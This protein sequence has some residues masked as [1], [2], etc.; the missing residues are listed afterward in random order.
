GGGLEALVLR[1]QC[2]GEDA[3]VAPSSDAELRGVGEAGGDYVID[4]GLQVDDFEVAPVRGDRG[5]ILLAAAGAAA[6]VHVHDDVAVG[7]EELPLEVERVGV[8][9]V[10]SAVDTEERRVFAAVLVV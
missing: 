7:G 2:V 4:G 10:R 9:A 5:L 6:I 3:A 1:D 8:L